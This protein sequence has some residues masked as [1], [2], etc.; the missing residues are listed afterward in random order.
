[1]R[2]LL[3]RIGYPNVTTLLLL[4]LLLRNYVSPFA[5]LDFA[6]QVRT[7]ELI[8]RTGQLHPPEAFTYTI[9]GQSINDFEWLYEVILYAIWSIFGYGGLKLL[10]TACVVV[11]IGLMGQRLRRGGVPWHGVAIAFWLAVLVLSPAW[12]LRPFFCTTTGLLLTTGWLHDHCKGTRP[13]PWRLVIV[14]LFWANLHPGVIL[15]QVLLVSAIGWEWINRWVKWNRPLDRVACVRLTIV[16]GAGLAA[17]FVSPCPLQQ[18]LYPFRSELAHPVQR[19]FVEM[20]PLSNFIALPPY[21]A[22]FAYLIAIPVGLSLILRPRQFRLWEAGLLIGLTG[23]ANLAIRSLTDW[24][25]LMLAIGG[26]QVAALVRQVQ[27]TWRAS[28]ARRRD[29]SRN[30]HLGFAWAHR[31]VRI[32]RSCRRMWQGCFLCFQPGWMVAALALLAIVSLCPPLSRRMPIQDAPQWPTAALDWIEARDLTGRF[33]GLPDFG[34]YVTWRRGDQAQ[35]YVD[36]RGFF[37]PPELIEDSLYVP[38]LGPQWRK[39]LDR[40]LDQGTDYFLLETSGPRGQFWHALQSE[41]PEPLFRDDQTV[42]VS[43]SQVRQ[44][45]AAATKEETSRAGLRLAKRP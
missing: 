34:S 29:P 10:K 7:G 24:I 45:I 38:F 26:P 41:I 43:A 22:G 6:W 15:G 19:C 5:D 39:R 3:V 12:N 18:L 35:T 31:L 44:A 11:P 9:A 23:M 30:T 17:S 27:N 20:M 32:D 2:S 1:M 4:I 42:L 13:L 25:L 36:T 40:V 33:F 16:S 37:F 8:V 14:M 21:T 28:V